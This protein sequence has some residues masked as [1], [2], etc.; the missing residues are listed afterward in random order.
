MLKIYKVLI[1]I[2]LWTLRLGSSKHSLV[3]KRKDRHIIWRNLFW[4]DE[5][6]AAL[7]LVVVASTFLFMMVSFAIFRYSKYSQACTL[8]SETWRVRYAAEAGI[9]YSKARFALKIAPV[10]EEFIIGDIGVS[11]K[12]IKK[13]NSVLEVQSTAIGNYK[14]KQ[15]IC[16]KK[17]INFKAHC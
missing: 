8:Y 13:D 2:C 9:A 4:Q 5:R 7:A 15:T 11:V 12:V 3:L 1:R 6:G 16:F 14:V 17:I 10:Q